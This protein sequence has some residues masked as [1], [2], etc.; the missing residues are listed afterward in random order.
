MA[1]YL[2][3]SICLSPIL[4]HLWAI[5]QTRCL[6][7]RVFRIFEESYLQFRGRL[8]NID[9]MIELLRPFHIQYSGL[10]LMFWSSLSKYLSYALSFSL[11][12]LI[13][14]YTSLH[15]IIF[16]HI[17]LWSSYHHTLTGKH[18]SL[19]AERVATAA[20]HSIRRRRNS[21]CKILSLSFWTLNQAIRPQDRM[22]KKGLC[23][24][25]QY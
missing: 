9:Q 6:C 15:I 18:A 1:L 19:S 8:C 21:Q 10:H 5:C 2:Q 20:Q 12:P 13:S 22:S 11:Y 24:R 3:P 23:P 7:L 14:S 17:I 4:R 16:F 25:S